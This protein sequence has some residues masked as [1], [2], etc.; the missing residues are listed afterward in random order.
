MTVKVKDLPEALRDACTERGMIADAEV[1]P[2]QAC[3][4]YC[5]WHYGIGPFAGELIDLYN[6]AMLTQTKENLTK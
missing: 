1:S 4:E 2:R 6:E 5:A 3:T